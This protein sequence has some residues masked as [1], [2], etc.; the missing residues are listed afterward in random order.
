MRQHAVFSVDNIPLWKER[1]LHWAAEQELAVYLDSNGH[2]GNPS[3]AKGWEC[4]VAAGVLQVLECQAG[5]AFEQLK[6]FQ[7][8]TKDWIFG[9]L[10]YDLK[11]ETERLSS[12]HFDG[13]GLPDLGFFQP[14]IVVGIRNGF[15]EVFF[16]NELIEV[17]FDEFKTF[18]QIVLKNKFNI[19]GVKNILKPRFDKEEYLETVEK[20]RSHIMEGDLY[21]MNLCQE[22]YAE[23]TGLDPVAVFARLN[24]IGQAPASAFLRWRDRYL[25][26][27]SPERFLQKR[28]DRLVSQPIKGT[29]RRGATMQEDAAIREELA[30]NEKDRAEH[31]MIV[32]LVRND[33]ARH[34]LPGSVRVDDLFGI[35]TF[36]TVH[37]MIST[38][39][40]DLRPGTHPIDALRDAFPMGSMTGAP[41]VIAMEL[42]ER[43]EKTRRGLYS[44][45]VGYFDP[46]DGFDFNVVIRSILYNA[47]S[48]YVSAQV[49]GAIV[50]DSVPEAEYEEC[51]LKLEAMQRALNARGEK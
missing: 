7:E 15:L 34:C 42:I 35:H 45:A 25:M 12:Q 1:L 28:G 13:I 2:E 21:E 29:R 16:K 10:S 39:S 6:Q 32:D 33:L 3:A 30:T 9:F 14:K 24:Q 27:A 36:E 20:I 40:G 5:N 51:L 17:L 41:K 4:L 43:Y 26:S 46:S 48:G 50:Y 22:F 18:D 11:N 8:E 23:K 49:G 31:I 38:V 19:I 44:G 47:S 37:Q